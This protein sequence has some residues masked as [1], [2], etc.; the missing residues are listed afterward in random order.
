MVEDY[1]NLRAERGNS[2]FD[3]RHDLRTSLGYD[4]PFGDRRRLLRSGTGAKVLGNWQLIN[5]IQYDSGNHLTPYITAQNTSGI[6][7]LLSQRPNMIGN[8]NLPS[9]QQTTTNFFNVAAFALPAVGQFGNASRGSIVGPPSFNVNLAIERRMHFGPDGKYT[10]EFRWET[11]NFTNTS[12]FS[13]VIT[14]VDAS[15]AGLITGAKAMRTMD[16]FLRL[17]F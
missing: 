7:P 12:N 1:S 8:P 6:G 14:V 15:D 13:N 11:Q 3:I 2:S 5:T 9:S 16:L 4:L 17:H 10:L